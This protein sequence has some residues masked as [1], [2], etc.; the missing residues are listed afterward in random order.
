MNIQKPAYCI[1]CGE[2]KNAV[3]DEAELPIW[4]QIQAKYLKKQVPYDGLIRVCRPCWEEKKLEMRV[5][6][7]P[8]YDN[9][10]E[11]KRKARRQELIATMQSRMINGE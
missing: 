2:V 6:T 3:W 7:P 10:P 5:I 11:E 9:W 8:D 1:V 4:P